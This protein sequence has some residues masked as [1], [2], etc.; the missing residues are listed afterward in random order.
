M[1]A[2]SKPNGEN[3]VAHRL[4]MLRSPAR[5]H[6]S[7]SAY[8]I[9]ER[10][11]IEHLLRGGQENGRLC[12][13]Y[14]QFQEHGIHKRQLRAGLRE[15]TGLGFIKVKRGQG[16]NGRF[17][18]P[19]LYTLTYLRVGKASPTDEWQYITNPEFVRTKAR[20]TVPTGMSA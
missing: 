11:E 4:A 15:L 1:T 12:V 5:R 6:L 8:R 7:L 17:R 14:E 16:G 18:A 19:N 20:K 3:W 2:K 10:L 9:L 13:T